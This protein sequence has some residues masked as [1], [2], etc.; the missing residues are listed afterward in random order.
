MNIYQLDG[1]AKDSSLALISGVMDQL[2]KTTLQCNPWKTY[3]YIP[4]VDFTMAYGS[5]CIFIKYFVLEKQLRSVHTDTNSNVFEDSCV[6]FFISFGNEQAYYNFECN[7]IGTCLAA[8]GSGKTNRTFLPVE[9][10]SQ[11]R[12]QSTIT[13][14]QEGEIRWELLLVIPLGVFYQHA[15]PELK[16]TVARAN[17]FKC[18]DLLPEPHFV[19][20]SDI[21][22]EQPDFHLPGF[23]NTVRFV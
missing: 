10:I 3:P 6:E 1:F 11:I 21:R 9:V 8:Y 12:R 20:W 16:G 19:A 22:S 13:R 5:D 14:E 23:F 2:E 4:Q 17:F 18:G 15:M 7:C